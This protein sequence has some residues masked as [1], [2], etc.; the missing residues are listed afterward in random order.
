MKKRAQKEP[1]KFSY[2]MPSLD[3]F[4]TIPVEIKPEDYYYFKIQRRYGPTW[5]I[6]GS[7]P[8]DAPE[9][10]WEDKEVGK[11]DGQDL[12]RFIEWAKTD[13]GSRITEISAISG[14]IDIIE[15]IK[16]LLS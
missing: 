10:H 13:I 11:I 6:I 14:S 2:T 16:K 9:Y 15:E 8:V 5:W 4:E 12:I 7:N 1:F 3:W